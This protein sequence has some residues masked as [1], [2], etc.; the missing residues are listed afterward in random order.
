M[1]SEKLVVV[2]V[3]FRI[4]I[5]KLKSVSDANNEETTV[6]NQNWLNFI[7][8]NSKRGLCSALDVRLLAEMMIMVMIIVGIL[9]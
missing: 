5:L 6:Y 8:N 9:S 3:I 1:L 7:E 2:T 4:D